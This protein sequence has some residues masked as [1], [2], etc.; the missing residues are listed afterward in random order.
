MK[1]ISLY[2]ML[3]VLVTG[4]AF[5]GDAGRETPFSLGAGARS[6]GMGGAFSALSDDAS[7]IYYNPAGLTR[8]EYQQ[9][10]LM[11]A[12]LFESSIYDFAAWVI[13]ISDRDGL[14][15]GF[16]RVGTDDII[17]FVDFDSAG[18][19]GYHQ[20]QVIFSYGREIIPRLSG[21]ISLKMVNQKL[22][23]F[24]D[25]AYGAD[26]GVS[27]KLTDLLSIGAIGRDLI[28]PKI[29]LDSSSETS[30][31]S[32]EGGIALTGFSV[33]EAMKLT[34][35]LDLEKIEDRSVKVHTG[36]EVSFYDNYFLRLGYDRDNISLGA[37]LKVKR[38]QFDYAYK[39][40]DY[41]DNSHRFSLTFLLGPSMTERRAREQAR[42]TPPA[43]P[44]LS[45]EE[46]K[47]R[48][49]KDQGDAFFRQFEF[50]SALA[51]YDRALTYKPSND[52]VL[53]T[54]AAIE[55]ARA[56]EREQQAKLKIA[57]QEVKQF[58]D[59]Y[60]SQAVVFYDKRY[61]PAA[62]DLLDL[63]FEIDPNNQRALE[64]KDEITAAMKAEIDRYQEQAR[65]AEREGRIVDAIDAYNNILYLQPNNET[66]IQAKQQALANLDVPQQLNLGIKLYTQGRYAEAKRRFESVL[67]TK[68]DEPV[69]LEYMKKIEEA[70]SQV[71]SLED[72][73]RDRA[74]WNLYLEGIRHMRNNEY[75]QAID[76][77]EKVLKAYP[78]NV[79]TLNNLEQARLRLQS[80]KKE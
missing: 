2:I 53:E 75:Q 35:A 32:F 60:L 71:S 59:R 28:A 27:V 65:Q 12:T 7:A 8:L 63:I 29:K 77:W 42:L 62:L 11:H 21:G 3:A 41:I 24:S 50:D 37:G 16:M 78:N 58:I 4:V 18:S 64:L 5:A 79:N 9:V 30:P 56:A 68:S 67:R 17:R 20:S 73:Q 25:Y 38:L 52:E 23:E 19:F 44:P 72:L 70:Q 14:G 54:I 48:E 61:Y 10:S 57:E 74:I 34:A 26:L 43:P 31:R 51:Y 33:S 36:A 49:F 45:E 22:D 46:R 13:P 69:A 76:A 80:E 55:R 40:M 39:L 66:V 1:R 15:I 6:L 47:F